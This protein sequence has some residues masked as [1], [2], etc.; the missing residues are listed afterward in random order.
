MSET[1]KIDVAVN[2]DNESLHA[3]GER[4]SERVIPEVYSLWLKVERLRHRGEIFKD[5]SVS[6]H[7]LGHDISHYDLD[8]MIPVHEAA[9]CCMYNYIVDRI[10]LYFTP[11]EVVEIESF[12]QRHSFHGVTFHKRRVEFSLK[13]IKRWAEMDEL[14]EVRYELDF[15]KWD[16]FD[17]PG[18][19]IASYYE[20]WFLAR[21]IVIVCNP[22]GSLDFGWMGPH[23]QLSTKE[24]EKIFNLRSEAITKGEKKVL[25]ICRE[26]INES[27]EDSLLRS[28]E[29]WNLS[30]DGEPQ[31]IWEFL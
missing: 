8:G 17:C 7:A 21:A 1:E 25:T 9:S 14:P 12:F 22:D 28:H 16:L 11:E 19:F 23:Q 31:V 10:K 13:D 26:A 20:S 4:T 30:S 29:D 18:R 2:K 24:I 27:N 5:V 15:S 6:I 3:K